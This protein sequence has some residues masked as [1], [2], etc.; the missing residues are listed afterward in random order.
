MPITSLIKKRMLNSIIKAAKEHRTIKI[1]Y[2]DSKGV[3]TF[4]RECEPYEIRGEAIYMYDLNK[5][6]IRLFKLSNINRAVLTTNTFVPRW[7]IQIQGG[8]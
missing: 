3:V 5:Q 6:S 4:D 8:L 1:S 7:P 2:T